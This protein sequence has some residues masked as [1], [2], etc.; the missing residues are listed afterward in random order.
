MILEHLCYFA[1]QDIPLF[2]IPYRRR[3][4]ARLDEFLGVLS[5]Y[6]FISPRASGDP[7]LVHPLIQLSMRNI[8]KE[9]TLIE[10]V[11]QRVFDE[12]RCKMDDDY[13]ETYQER[14]KWNSF[15]THA[16]SA[17]NYRHRMDLQDWEKIPQSR[18][19]ISLCTYLLNMNT[20]THFN[21]ARKIIVDARTEIRGL[22]WEGWVLGKKNLR[23]GIQLDSILALTLQKQ[24]RYSQAEDIHWECVR[25]SE[26]AYG[27]E[28][29][30]TLFQ[31]I[32]LFETIALRGRCVEAIRGLK[33]IQNLIRRK[34]ERP[35]LFLRLDD[36]D[37]DKCEQM[38]PKV[39]LAL[40]E[41]LFLQKSYVEA[42]ALNEQILKDIVAAGLD[43]DHPAA[44]KVKARLAAIESDQGRHAEAAQTLSQALDGM[45]RGGWGEHPET[46]PVMV[47]LTTALTRQGKYAAG[48]KIA[49]D[50]MEIGNRVLDGSHPVYADIVFALAV[51]LQGQEKLTNATELFEHV[52]VVR[53]DM[54]GLEHPATQECQKALKE[55]QAAGGKGDDPAVV[56]QG[57]S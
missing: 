30:E 3:W 40:A 28:G 10:A 4:G 24:G 18:L 55:A 38:E 27:V 34:K 11:L 37:D 56:E 39:I 29:C 23:I 45:Q 16:H 53:T 8:L 12:L 51:S 52:M 9:N 14:E 42:T 7:V 15:Y 36:D 57:S 21:Q 43:P 44:W 31:K 2:L 41:A 25:N 20:M 26:K 17:W 35:S 19:A 54:L 13:E 47:A 50:A 46:F 48:E 6:G 32:G 1:E 33:D 22:E 5:S 49:A